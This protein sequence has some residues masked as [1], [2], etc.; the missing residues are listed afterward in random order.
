[1]LGDPFIIIIIIIIIAPS[2]FFTPA[3]DNGLSQESEWQQV[4]SDLQIFRT[5]LIILAH[6]YNA[7]VWMVSACPPISNSFSPF[8]NPLGIV[9]CALITIGITFNIMFQS[10]I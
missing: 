8:T 5:L 1:M 6:L 4:S 2:E 9:P 7:V 3:L 10:F